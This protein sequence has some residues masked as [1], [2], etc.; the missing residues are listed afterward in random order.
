MSTTEAPAPFYICEEQHFVS[1][2]RS[3]GACKAVAA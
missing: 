3:G 1:A 2:P